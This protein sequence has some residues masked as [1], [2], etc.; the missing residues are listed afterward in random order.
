MSTG[1]ADPVN[2]DRF[3]SA[4]GWKRSRVS[5]SR[6]D[7]VAVDPADA[8]APG[9]AEPGRGR[10]RQVGPMAGPAPSDVDLAIRV[11]DALHGAPTRSVAALLLSHRTRLDG[12]ADW[13]VAERL[14]VSVHAASQSHGLGPLWPASARARLEDQ[15]SRQ[16]QRSASLL[17]A[18]AEIDRAFGR[19]GIEYLVLKG[20]PLSERLEGGVGRRFTWDLDLLVRERD[21]PRATVA[22]GRVGFSP[23]RL[24]R[25]LLPIARKVAHAVEFRRDDGLAVDLH[26][27]FRRLPGLRFPADEVFAGRRSIALDGTA[28]PVPSDEHLLA[29]LLLGIAADAD[30]GLCR[31]RA[32]RDTLMLLREMKS[33]DW[34]GFLE[35]REAE[36]CLGLAC[37]A[38]ALVVYAFRAE[39][40]FRA[41]LDRIA[42]VLGRGGRSGGS[43]RFLDILARSAHDPRNHLEYAS[44]QDLPAPAYWSWWAATLPARAF[45][46]RRL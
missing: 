5:T 18:L 37:H 34:K 42:P 23:P 22:L 10:A 19:D 26:W 11:L 36:G 17:G 21:L 31:W 8:A 45:F 33:T 12:L 1:F 29:Q 13:F 30:R 39:D 2:A 44:W 7:I 16:Q 6:G 46:A 27:A 14:G 38:L 32:L 3:A 9:L 43:D 35:L 4:D 40:E 24:A 41:L 25:G 28:F 15:W 20:L